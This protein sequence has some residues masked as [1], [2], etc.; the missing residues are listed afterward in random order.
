MK[1]ENMRLGVG[2]EGQ[3]AGDIGE[4]TRRYVHPEELGV[5]PECFRPEAGSFVT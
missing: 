5:E 3:A 4:K 1:L 2:M